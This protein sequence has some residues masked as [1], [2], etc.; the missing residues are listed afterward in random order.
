MPTDKAI[1]IG[2]GIGGIATA[3]RLA[4]KGYSVEV[5]EKNEVPGGKLYLIE[6][7]GYRFDA[8]PSL[9]TQPVNI[10][11]LFHLA[12]E[13]IDSYFEYEK[14]DIACRYFFE[15]GKILNAHTH[16]PSFANEMESV[17]GEPAGNVLQYLKD[18]ERVYENVGTIFLNHSLHKMS[19]W[20]HP[21]ILT[22]LKTIRWQ[23]M[24]R[25]LD[26]FNRGRFSTQ[27]AVQIFNRFATYN[28]SNPYRAPGMLS[29]I[30]HLEQNQGT[31]YPK[32]GMISIPKALVKLAEKKGVK[33][34]LNTRVE[35]IVTV[36]G[37]A[38]GIISNGIFCRADV[39]VSNVDAYYTYKDLLT[40]DTAASAILKN[41]RSSSAL[42]FYWGMKES[43]SEL[44]LH[45]IFFSKNYNEEFDHLFSRKKF[46][47][48]P[49]VYVNI[50][51]KMEVGQAPAGCENWFVMVNAPAIADADWQKEINTL[52][53]NVVDKLSR[54]LGR[55][56]GAAI[57]VEEVISPAGIQSR[58]DSYLGSLYGTSSNSKWAAFLRHPNSKPSIEGLYFTGGSVH[59]GGGIPL[60]LKSAAIVSNMVPSPKT[61]VGPE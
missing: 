32:G 29:L 2:A 50:T 10:E 40:D 30:P 7:E 11:E 17:L 56:I 42:I 61:K 54:I 15:N 18:A 31:F 57:Q 33:F 34:I 28:G 49:T 21:R 59:P 25:T 3:I 6:K 16:A 46:Y 47:D 1:V 48:D 58:T 5:H 41:E 14:V 22:A 51:S 38:K 13:D 43:F 35:K 52:K 19:T 20:L 12:G 53:R 26:Q 27:E 9:F 45:N 24:F 8:G 55:D 39:V 44:H 23:Y 4:S 36:G 60:C 37:F